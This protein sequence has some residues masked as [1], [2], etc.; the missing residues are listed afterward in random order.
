MFTSLEKHFEVE[1]EEVQGLK[2]KL[3]EV[4]AQRDNLEQESLAEKER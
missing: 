2:E 1:C 3:A 4:T